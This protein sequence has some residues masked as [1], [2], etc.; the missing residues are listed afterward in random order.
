V[1]TD[2]LSPPEILARIPDSRAWRA[3]PLA[4][5]LP[6]QT[7][8]VNEALQ[9]ARK[10]GL[11][12]PPFR[13]TWVSGGDRLYGKTSHDPDGRN[14]EVTLSVDLMPDQLFRTSLHELK[15]VS[16]V[17]AG[18]RFDLHREEA[19]RRAVDFVRRVGALR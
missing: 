9:L 13:L 3:L 2:D 8:I 6:A 15:H 5:P 17:A 12:L 7:R 19:E 11:Q 14:I 18:F 4:D 16:D 1:N 10:A